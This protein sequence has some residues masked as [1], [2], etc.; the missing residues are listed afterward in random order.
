MGA[1]EFRIP[2][3]AVL[4]LKHVARSPE[5][6]SE[7]EPIAAALPADASIQDLAERFA[8]K[9]GVPSAVGT[10]IV[11]QLAAIHHVRSRFRLDSG[12]LFEMLT[13]QLAESP[14]WEKSDLEKW[15]A[16][17]K[18]IRAVLAPDHP[19]AILEKSERLNYDR[20]NILLNARILTDLRPV[21]NESADEIQRAIV[22]QLL[23][24]EYTDS[25]G[26]H[27]QLRLAID[28][29]DVAK[30][31]ELCDRADRKAAT[32]CEDLQAQSWSALIPGR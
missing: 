26:Q 32:L 2:P 28:A 22:T 11:T 30:F 21:Y 8:K 19:L 10:S 17:E 27:N 23:C 5:Y 7:I 15:T 4:A 18:E 20:Q 16:A 1:F 31:R 14:E 13:E 6:L 24:L 25:T 29:E 3:K 9:V 12:A